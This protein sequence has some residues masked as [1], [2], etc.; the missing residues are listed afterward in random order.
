MF[1]G[2]VKSRFSKPH[3]T[4]TWNEPQKNE[5]FT[6]FKS[7]LMPRPRVEERN[8]FYNLAWKSYSINNENF[9]RYRYKL[10]N[11][12]SIVQ[13]LSNGFLDLNHLVTKCLFINLQTIEAFLQTYNFYY[14]LMIVDDKIPKIGNVYLIKY[15]GY[16]KIGRTFNFN[17]RY[18]KKIREKAVIVAPVTND[19]EDEARLIKAYKD[20][21]YELLKGKEFFK[22]TSFEDVKRIFNATISKKITKT[23]YK[24]SIYVQSVKKKSGKSKLYIHPRI[25]PIFINKFAKTETE[26]KSLNNFVD[27]VGNQISDGYFDVVY[28]QKLDTNRRNHEELNNISIQRWNDGKIN[29]SRL[30]NSIKKVE[31]G[32]K[33]KPISD[34]FKQ[35]DISVTMKKLF[36]KEFPGQ[37]MWEKYINDE[38]PYLSGYYMHWCL[39]VD[40]VKWAAP[41]NRIKISRLLINTNH[42]L[43]NTGPVITDD[44][45]V[46]FYN[47]SK[48]LVVRN[49]LSLED[50]LPS[51]VLRMENIF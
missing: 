29:V 2:G 12:V 6:V 34:F 4:P 3:S 11:D 25:A 39:I 35:K 48:S 41:Q 16:F 40:F 26:R 38:Q 45:E 14:Q 8:R 51:L 7:Q 20:A 9:R 13:K 27:L 37:T 43:F 49:N 24:S 18:E 19:E 22:Y 1:L 50:R 30:Y 46:K 32:A 36:D 23:N 33:Y 28:D 21:G 10:Y 15:K 5:I 47:E 42:Q 17:K 44:N 31:G